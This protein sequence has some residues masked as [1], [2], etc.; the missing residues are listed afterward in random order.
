MAT[1]EVK[2]V[3]KAVDQA[4]ATIKKVDTALGNTG[5]TSGG[6]KKAFSDLKNQIPGLGGAMSALSNP[7][8]LIGSGIGA[9]AKLTSDSINGW[10][11]YNKQM[12]EMSL[13]TGIGVEEI[14]RITQVADD[15]GIS[16]DQVS[17]SLSFANKNGFSP[18]IDNLAKLAD[19][20]VNTADKTEFAKKAQQ[21]FGRS[22]ATMIPI[23]AKG[24]DA[25][26][27]NTDA[28]SD[29]LVATDESVAATREYEVAV[30]NLRDSMTGVKNTLAQEVLPA[31]TN[32]TASIGEATTTVSEFISVTRQLKKINLENTK[33][34]ETQNKVLQTA[35]R[36]IGGPLTSIYYSAKDGLV[37]MGVATEA[38][39]EA[40]EEEEK[41]HGYNNAVIARET[42]SRKDA[43]G[44]LTE[45]TDEIDDNTEAIAAN[46]LAMEENASALKEL[47]GL[48]SGKLGPTIADFTAGQADLET[49]MQDVQAAIAKAIDEGYNPMG[50]EVQELQGQYDELKTQYDENATAHEEA[51]RRILF[52]L[53]AQKASVNGLSDAELEVLTAVALNWGLV[54]E[55]TAAAGNAFSDALDMVSG[56]N[57]DVKGAIASI[58][59]IGTT[60]TTA[61]ESFAIA[62]GVAAGSIAPTQAEIDAMLASVNELS[63]TH[64][65]H[66]DITTSG[67]VPN[68]PG[69]SVYGSGDYNQY[70]SGTDF[71]IP[72]GYNENYP[73]GFG[74]SGERVVVIPEGKSGNTTT[75]NFSMYVHTN[76]GASTLARDFSIMQSLTR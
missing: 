53:L 46:E 2:T 64:D 33:V 45:N 31:V 40:V 7:V 66:F 47:Q 34:T 72:P 37:A 18:T 39:T 23:L 25:L 49:Q 19:E 22:Y 28:V 4:S 43:S 41:A 58:E 59:S 35:Y 20:Y 74:S 75:N 24:G 15:W 61:G 57:P 29:S 54:D 9:L 14:S 42:A 50:V 5:K 32:V 12:R 70:A 44:T 13:V 21:I 3:F 67:N 26:R 68:I 60:A 8:A 69:G 27:A 52:D 17:A 30:D 56:D 1:N 10:V 11:E 38:M 62:M 65:I 36:F 71:V 63:G 55:A 76:A 48:I 16:V 51:T 73:I 6:L